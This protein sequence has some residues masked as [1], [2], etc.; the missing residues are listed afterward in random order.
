MFLENLSLGKVTLHPLSPKKLSNGNGQLEK[1][2]HRKFSPVTFENFQMENRHMA[3]CNL[4]N[5]RLYCRGY[6]IPERGL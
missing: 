5:Y 2:P 6:E 3:N 1:M 4:T